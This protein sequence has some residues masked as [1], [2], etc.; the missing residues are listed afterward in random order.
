MYKKRQLVWIVVL[1]FLAGCSTVS[2]GG[3]KFTESS[4]C[5]HHNVQMKE[6]PVVYGYP[7]EELMQKSQK[8]EVI[9]GGCIIKDDNPKTGYICPIDGEIFYQRQDTRT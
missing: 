5:P 7:D 6:A 2:F 1:L 4:L 8:G 3:R 9:L